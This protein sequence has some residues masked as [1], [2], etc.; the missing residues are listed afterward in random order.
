MATL[1]IIAHPNL[2]Q[3]RINK[4]WVEYLR[5]NTD[6]TLHNLYD[7][8]PS[9]II[10]VAHEQLLLSTHDRIVFQYPLYWYSSPPL[11]KK[12]LDTVLTNGWAYGT[13]GNKLRGKEMLI[14]ISTGAPQEAYQ[15]GGRNKFTLKEI[16]IPMEATAN[17]I[18]MRMLPYF[19]INSARLVTDEELSQSAAA[20]AAIVT[21]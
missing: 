1:V 20:Y 7:A 17:L 21:A 11:L 4:H 8:Y 16:L 3:S 19:A 9:E 13:N 14:A 15:M 12:W 5:A 18:G 10:D 2:E 6:V